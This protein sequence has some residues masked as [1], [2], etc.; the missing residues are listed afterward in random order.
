MYSLGEM[1]QDGRGVPEDIGEALN[2]FRKAAEKGHSSAM[3]KLGKAYETGEGVKPD[4]QESVRWFQKAADAD[5]GDGMYNLALCYRKGQGVQVDTNEA[6]KWLLRATQ[7]AETNRTNFNKQYPQLV[8][9]MQSL[10]AGVL[11]DLYAK[12]GTISYLTGEIVRRFRATAAKQDDQH[13]LDELIRQYENGDPIQPDITQSAKWTRKAAELGRPESMYEIAQCYRYGRGVETN[14]TEAAVW[15]EKSADAGNILGSYEIGLCYLYGTGV[16]VDTGKAYERVRV[17][18]KK[19]NCQ[20]MLSLAMCLREG[21][22]T[23]T[24]AQEAV[25]WFTKAYDESYVTDK[26]D[27]ALQLAIAYE[28][29]SG[30]TKSRADATK[31]FERYAESVCEI[32][33]HTS[34]ASY[35][36]YCVGRL[37]DLGFQVKRDKTEAAR[38]YAKASSKGD[39][40]AMTE[41]G[42]MYEDGETL[43]QNTILAYA[44]YHLATEKGAKHAKA[45]RDRIALR[46][47]PSQIATAQKEAQFLAQQQEVVPASSGDRKNTT[48]LLN[49]IGTGFFVTSDGYLVTAAHVVSKSAAVNIAVGE[50]TIPVRIVSVDDR[51]DI[52]LLKAE[53]SFSALSLVPSRSVKLGGEVFTLGFP[54]VHLQGISPKLTK[55]VVSGLNGIQDDPSCFQI[56]VA[57]QPGNSGGPLINTG[58]NVVGV[59]NARLNDLATAK[60]TGSLPQNVNYAVKSAYVLPLL[61]SILEGSQLPTVNQTMA[62]EEAV[63]LA[64]SAIC[65]ILAQ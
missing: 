58:G 49:A 24:N 63:K 57:V 45:C 41:L 46:L 38:W 16:P 42:K 4:A 43:P 52:A 65:I 7:V 28:T 6:A 18:A 20:A 21:K 31:W 1:Y 32:T 29:G 54:N 33:R 53:G 12:G 14:Q 62:F 51:N 8:V 59:I 39:L 13:P 40:L 50:R 25:R 27:A 61:D 48:Q 15:Y 2:C 34:N 19:G 23:P 10:H 44:W 64:E 55:G 37:Y 11:A 17:A 56:S 36:Y 30:V 26:H 60:L 47:L 3:V 35:G 5:D 22:G 9:S